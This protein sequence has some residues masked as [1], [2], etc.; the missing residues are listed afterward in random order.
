MPRGRRPATPAD[1]PLPVPLAGL[2]VVTLDFTATVGRGVRL[3]LVA[4]GA[5]GRVSWSLAGHPGVGD[6]SEAALPPG[7]HLDTHGITGIPEQPGVYFVD[8]VATDQAHPERRQTEATV[9]IT[10]E[11]ADTAQ[12]PL[13]QTLHWPDNLRGA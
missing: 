13:T 1:P 5:D 10:V 8:I 7:M 11:D 9:V 12:P 2:R 4:D 3:V 6:A